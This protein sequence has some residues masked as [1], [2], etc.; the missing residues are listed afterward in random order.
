MCN[1]YCTCITRKPTVGQHAVHR[2]IW[3]FAIQGL[4][5]CLR[6]C[7][8]NSCPPARPPCPPPG[9]LGRPKPKTA[10]W[11][12]KKREEK[13][14]SASIVKFKQVEVRDLS[15]D[16]CFLRVW[17][18]NTR[19]GISASQNNDSVICDFCLWDSSFFRMRTKLFESL[20]DASWVTIK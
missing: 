15:F 1:K 12:W 6:L 14:I 10:R 2:H 17:Q 5:C 20:T 11:L 19:T 13:Q 8:S 3:E 7:V 9:Y 16:I 4:F 18:M